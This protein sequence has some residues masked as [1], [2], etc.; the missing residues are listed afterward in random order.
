MCVVKWLDNKP[1]LMA[2]TS[3]GLQSEGLVRCWSKKEKKYI[4]VKCPAIVMKYNS[5]MVGVD[6]SDRMISYYRTRARTK[7]WTIRTVFHF[8]DLAVTNAWIQY[9]NDRRH[10]G[11]TKRNYAGFISFIL[12]YLVF[13]NNVTVLAIHVFSLLA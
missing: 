3:T 10:F 2:S 11:P 9:R 1:V 6:M 8:F 7:K 12:L 5:K 4:N 13:N